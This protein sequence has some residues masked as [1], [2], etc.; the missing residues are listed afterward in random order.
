MIRHTIVSALLVAIV[1]IVPTAA[2]SWT[3]MARAGETLEQLSVRYYGESD[4]SIVIRAANGFIHP[5]DGRLAE[6]E[7]VIVPEI[8]YI[9]VREGESWESLANSFLSSPRRAN[10]LAE[11]NELPA[12]QMPP[13]GAI[14]KIPY[15]LR[16]IFAQNETLRSVARLYYKKEERSLEWLRKYNSSS[17]KKYTRG[18]V[19]IIPLLDLRFTDE[20]QQRIDA[21][22]RNLSNRADFVRQKEAREIIAKLKTNYETGRYVQMVSSASKLLGYG[23]L[24]VPQEIGIYNYL[25]YAYVALGEHRMAVAAFQE[26]LSRQPEMELSSITT[27]PKIL[28][29]FNEAKTRRNAPN[30]PGALQKQEKNVSGEAKK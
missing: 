5:D 6:G 1:S 19:I 29:A 26:A 25:A 12:D 7:P 30:N 4:K 8:T 28:K 10:F 15:H 11:M 20:E 9:H 13:L 21:Y 18:E 2:F 24:T 17:R 23:R 14:I 22:R 16:H 3:H 27:S